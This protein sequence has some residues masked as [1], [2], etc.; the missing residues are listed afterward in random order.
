METALEIVLDIL[1]Y[2]IIGGFMVVGVWIL[3]LGS[4]LIENKIRRDKK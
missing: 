3:A 4:I 1:R 2:L